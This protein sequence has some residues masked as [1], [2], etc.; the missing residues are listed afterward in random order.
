MR[1]WRGITGAI[2]LTD[3]ILNEPADVI[4][5]I[6]AAILRNSQVIETEYA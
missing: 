6:T 1:R 5:I 4:K 2:R 3:S